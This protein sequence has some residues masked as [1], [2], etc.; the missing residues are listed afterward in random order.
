MWYHK[1]C[2]YIWEFITNLYTSQLTPC[3][4][5]CTSFQ[6][7]LETWVYMLQQVPWVLLG[8]WVSF[9]YN[10]ITGPYWLFWRYDPGPRNK[11]KSADGW[12]SAIF[13]FTLL[14]FTSLGCIVCSTLFVQLLVNYKGWACLLG[15]TALIQL[16]PHPLPTATQALNCIILILQCT[17]PITHHVNYPLPIAITYHPLET[18]ALMHINIMNSPTAMQCSH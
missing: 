9:T 5:R 3:P 10:E 17:P 15:P 1:V 11:A 8:A 6:G 13:S 14:S 16:I 2:I 4:P 18:R 7:H 12:C